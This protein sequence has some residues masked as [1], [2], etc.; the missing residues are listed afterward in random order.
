M[1]WSFVSVSVGKAK[2]TQNLKPKKLIGIPICHSQVLSVHKIILYL[3]TTFLSAGHFQLLKGTCKKI[4]NEWAASYHF[5]DNDSNDVVNWYILQ[6]NMQGESFQT[7][8]LV[9]NRIYLK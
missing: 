2:K 9:L 5:L 7:S 4:E 8:H 6:G 1:S 3:T